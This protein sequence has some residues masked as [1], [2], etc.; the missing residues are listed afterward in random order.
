MYS[1][2]IITV[3][4]IQMKVKSRGF[5]IPRMNPTYTEIDRKSANYCNLWVIANP[6]QDGK[7]AD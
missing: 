6:V 3:F 1:P 5:I 4:M 2:S 7:Q